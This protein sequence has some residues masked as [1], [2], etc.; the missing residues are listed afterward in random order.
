MGKMRATRLSELNFPPEVY[1]YARSYRLPNDADLGR[2]RDIRSTCTAHL[3]AIEGEINQLELPKCWYIRYDLRAEAARFSLQVDACDSLI[4]I[5]RQ[6]PPELLILIFQHHLDTLEVDGSARLRSLA[7]LCL[8][9]SSWRAAAMSNPA[10]WCPVSVSVKAMLTLSNPTVFW[11]LDEP[12]LALNFRMDLLHGYPWT[13]DL[14]AEVK[15]DWAHAPAV[16]KER[17]AL[18]EAILHHPSMKSLGRLTVECTSDNHDLLG[19]SFPSVDSL[20]MQWTRD[21][22]KASPRLPSLPKLR[23]A[24][25]CTLP[26]EF[27][28]LPI[29]QLTHLYIGGPRLG[30]KTWAKIMHIC[31]RLVKG[32]FVLAQKG[33]YPGE[34]QAPGSIVVQEELRELTLLIRD[35]FE[36][37]PSAM[38]FHWPALTKFVLYYGYIRPTSWMPALMENFGF[39]EG[40]SPMLSHLTLVG[41]GG[42][43]GNRLKLLQQL[44]LL[45]ELSLTVTDEAEEIISWLSSHTNREFNLPHLKALGFR[46]IRG[47]EAWDPPDS[48]DEDLEV[49]EGRTLWRTRMVPFLKRLV[50]ARKKRKDSGGEEPSIES[51]VLKISDTCQG[52]T[53]YFKKRLAQVSGL[54]VKI[55]VEEN[56]HGLN[57]WTRESNYGCVFK[58][59]DEGFEDFIGANRLCELYPTV[60]LL[61]EVTETERLQ[62]QDI[63]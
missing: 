19:Y 38:L 13:L 21:Y 11:S 28:H 22:R 63:T 25:F 61:H 36:L 35:E 3:A 1:E 33:D 55:S 41:D 27:F 32:C 12:M 52:T 4:S 46:L 56:N 9:S 49:M 23:K 60:G 10:F 8:V 7:V 17:F 6:I 47:D 42:H 48:Q 16:P 29:S 20:V 57:L 34:T 18:L 58:H 24:V 15:S 14:R 62:S 53:R 31:T 26:K 50:E 30:V 43:D 5:H 45:K 54:G 59:W 40:R 2:I 39:G 37:R 44:P 51:L